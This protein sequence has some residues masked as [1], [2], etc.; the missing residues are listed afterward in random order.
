MRIKE[1]Q[2]LKRVYHYVDFA[3]KSFPLAFPGERVG[4]NGVVL[5]MDAGLLAINDIMSC[6]FGKRLPLQGVSIN[7]FDLHF[8]GQKCSSVFLCCPIFLMSQYP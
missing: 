6:E 7:C 4:N 2:L 5:Q 3:S 8:S 1:K